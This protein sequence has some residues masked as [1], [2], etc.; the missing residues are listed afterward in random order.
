[1]SIELV[2]SVVSLLVGIGALYFAWRAARSG[3]RSVELSERSLKASKEQL[4][5]A[6]REAEMRPDLKVSC[7]IMRS[8]RDEEAGTLRVEVHNSGKVAAHNVRGWIYIPGVFFGPPKPPPLSSWTIPV[9]QNRSW[10]VIF[11]EGAEPVEDGW[12]QAQVYEREELLSG[13]HRTFD[14]QVTLRRGGKTPVF[15]HV[16]CNEGAAFE[17]RL[18]VEVPKQS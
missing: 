9:P 18:E 12:Y 11:D 5:I 10:G 3:E 16:V 1:V 7:A 4:L 13:S 15:C 2:V 8:A 14:I 6:R 17:D